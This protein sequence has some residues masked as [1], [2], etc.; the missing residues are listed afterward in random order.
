VKDIFQ[1]QSCGGE[2]D[3][4]ALAEARWY[5]FSEALPRSCLACVQENLLRILL[6]KGEAAL[7][8]A[9]QTVWPLDAEAAFGALPSRLRRHADPRFSGKA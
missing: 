8:E 7:H 6:A 5:P 9:V 4:N 3:G 2:V 1:C